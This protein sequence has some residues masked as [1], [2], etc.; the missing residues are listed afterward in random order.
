MFPILIVALTSLWVSYRIYLTTLRWFIVFFN[1]KTYDCILCM[2]DSA[3]G[4]LLERPIVYTLNYSW[5]RSL[6]FSILGTGSARC[7]IL[8][9]VSLHLSSCYWICLVSI[10]FAPSYCPRGVMRVMQW[11]FCLVAH[12][13]YGQ[14]LR[15]CEFNSYPRHSFVAG[16]I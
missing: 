7:F 2:S 10:R 13:L 15:T 3:S 11:L 5:C 16:Y 9:A 8:P 1:I 12:T 4:N 6:S 14:M